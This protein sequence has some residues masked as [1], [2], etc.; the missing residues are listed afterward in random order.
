MAHKG[1]Q[2]VVMDVI[3]ITGCIALSLTAALILYAGVTELLKRQR[4]R[5]CPPVEI[6]T[7]VGLHS[8]R[9]RLEAVQLRGALRRAGDR[10]RRELRSDLDDLRRR[11]R[12]KR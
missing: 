1:T 12:S 11:T 4:A 8:V 6:R 10:A 7:Q 9:R 3:D 5:R 2:S